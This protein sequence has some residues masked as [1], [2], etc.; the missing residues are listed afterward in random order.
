MRE[1]EARQEKKCR[2]IRVVSVSLYKET[3]PVTKEN[4]EK[5]LKRI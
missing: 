3:I 2:G 5:R 4:V 1:R